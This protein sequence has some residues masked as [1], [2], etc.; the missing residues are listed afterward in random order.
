M[1]FSWDFSPTK[2]ELRHPRT[3]HSKPAD[4]FMKQFILY[5]LGEQSSGNNNRA[6]E[7]L[8]GDETHRQTHVLTV[9]FPAGTVLAGDKLYSD[10][11]CVHN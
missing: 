4:E 7:L 6:R 8:L 9:K 11:L 5:S 2:C 10:G 3:N 1:Y